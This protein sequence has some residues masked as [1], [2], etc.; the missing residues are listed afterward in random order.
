MP[1]LTGGTLNLV[2]PA[3]T[4]DHK[5][6]IGTD[7]PANFQKIDDEF[8]AHLADTT[9]HL[10]TGNQT[11]TGQ[12][13]FINAIGLLNHA[14]AIKRDGSGAGLFQFSYSMIL[15]YAID[16]STPANYLVAIGFKGLQGTDTH[17][18]NVLHS[19]GLTLGSANASG[20]QIIQGGAATNIMAYGISIPMLA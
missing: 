4:D 5:V 8:T 15:L 6:T 14:R 19:A 1:T 3:L 10:N 2:K 16:T 12:K 18:L 13:T 9:M 20:T 7:L 11:I 17:V